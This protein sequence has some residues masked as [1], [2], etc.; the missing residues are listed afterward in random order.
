[1]AKHHD[2]GPAHHPRARGAAGRCAIVPGSRHAHGPGQVRRRHAQGRHAG[3]L[4][5]GARPHRRPAGRHRRR[6]LHDPRRLELVRRPQE[7][8]PGRLR[9]GPGGELPHPAGEPDRRLRRQR[10][11]H[12]PARPRHFPGRARLRALGRA[13]RQ[14]AG[15]LRRARH[16][17]GRTGGPRDPLALVG[18]GGRARA[19]CLPPARRWWSARSAR[20]SPRRSSA[21]RRS[22]WTIAGTI[23]NRVASEDA[24]FAE[25]KRF[26]SYMPTNVWELPPEAPCDRSG[27]SLRRWPAFD[28]AEG[29][30]PALQHEE[31]GRR[32]WST[33]TPS[34]RS[35]RR[36]ARR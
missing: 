15:R 3:A 7:G 8:R 5:H 36:S 33:A 11:L 27:R 10:H 21:G 12:Q 16:G 35:S 13:A 9:R 29:P 4:R 17:R 14:G 24:C 32:T 34:S 22:R 28:R 26:L 30:A 23:D 2:R 25:I 19:R 20:R 18:D 6:G 31:A 1:M